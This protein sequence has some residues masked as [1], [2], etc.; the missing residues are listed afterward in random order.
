MWK[1]QE[2]K[3]RQLKNTKIFKRRTPSP[4]PKSYT[5]F[6]IGP[7]TEKSLKS[8]AYFDTKQC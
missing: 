7:S 3:S 8:R 1:L 4:S 5:P 2:I 6:T